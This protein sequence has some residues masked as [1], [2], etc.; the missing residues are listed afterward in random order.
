MNYIVCDICNCIIQKGNEA[1][2][3]DYYNIPKFDNLVHDNLK[4]IDVC[5]KCLKDF[6]KWMKL[7]CEDRSEF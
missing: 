6:H 5:E 1:Q 4:Y 2:H 7:H 3:T